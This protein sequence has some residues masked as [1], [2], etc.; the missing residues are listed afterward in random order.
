M[1]HTFGSRFWHVCTVLLLNR[2][3]PL[4]V[5]AHDNMVKQIPRHFLN[6]GNL[7][8]LNGGVEKH[9]FFLFFLVDFP[10]GGNHD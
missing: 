5:D 6:K 8:C 1:H 2:R 3:L 9:L 7:V 4:V 10:I